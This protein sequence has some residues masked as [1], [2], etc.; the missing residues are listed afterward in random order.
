MIALLH[1]NLLLQNRSNHRY[2]FNGME[3]D[4]DHTQGKYNFGARI[5][6]SR[7]VRWFSIHPVFQPWQS[8]YNSMDGNPINLNDSMGLDPGD[9]ISENDGSADGKDGVATRSIEGFDV[10]YTT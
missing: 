1:N 7:L 2:G 6:D 4:D 10:D 8:P 9:V 3:K 5:Y